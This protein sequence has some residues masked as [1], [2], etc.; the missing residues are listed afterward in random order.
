M[1]GSTA[2]IGGV[3]SV[4]GECGST[5]TMEGV[6]SEA[7]AWSTATIGSVNTDAKAGEYSHYRRRQFRGECRGVQPL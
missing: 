7:N 2:T 3:N 6:N 1:P 5:A 4:G